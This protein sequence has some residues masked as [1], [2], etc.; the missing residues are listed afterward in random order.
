MSAF[1]GPV[2]YWLYRKIQYQEQL[3][4]KILK[5]ICPQLNEIV[6][7][8]CGTIQ[9]GSL[10]EIIDHQAIHQWLSMELM[11]VE[12]RF[13]FIVEHIEKSDFEEVREVLFEAGK[14]ISINEN[15]HNCIE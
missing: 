11:I 7:Q 2:H 8:E 6:A 10:E 13:A 15:Y 9:D 12:K 4:Q 14:E 5:R 3:N 1:L